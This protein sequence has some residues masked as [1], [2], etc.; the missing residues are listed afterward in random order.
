MSTLINTPFALEEAI[1]EHQ[2]VSGNFFSAFSGA[3]GHVQIGWDDQQFVA[4]N[5]DDEPTLLE[6]GDIQMMLPLRTL[7]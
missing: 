4:R 6:A 3:E 2:V 5:A 1:K 7:N